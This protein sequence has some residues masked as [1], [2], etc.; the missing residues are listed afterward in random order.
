M[1]A[2]LEFILDYELSIS[3]LSDINGAY[4]PG[5][6]IERQEK[7]GFGLNPKDFEVGW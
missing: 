4:S 2:S 3:E 5:N 6:D 7:K 1:Y